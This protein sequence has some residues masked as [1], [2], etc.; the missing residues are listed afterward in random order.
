MREVN[1]LRSHN[2]R[3]R[4]NIRVVVAWL[5]EDVKAIRDRNVVDGSV[6]AIASFRKSKVYFFTVDINLADRFY[7]HASEVCFRACSWSC[8]SPAYVARQIF[9][10][11]WRR[12][13]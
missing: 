7:L 8:Q 10:G 2:R 1:F 6:I 3:Q 13:I 4:V 11:R 12:D 5:G 9:K